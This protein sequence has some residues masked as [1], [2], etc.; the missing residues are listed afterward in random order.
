LLNRSHRLNDR[1]ATGADRTTDDPYSF[2]VRHCPVVGDIKV[3]L[4]TPNPP[5][6]IANDQVSIAAIG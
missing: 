5:L 1:P 3:M 4:D 6:L 2:I